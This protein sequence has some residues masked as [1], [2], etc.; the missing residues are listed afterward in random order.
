MQF[1]G[2]LLEESVADRSVLDLLTITKTETWNVANATANQPRVWHAVYYEGDINN[3]DIIAK[4]LCQSL[5]AGEWY[6]NFT[7]N[8]QVHVIFPGKVFV[9]L[10]GDKASRGE[11]QAYGRSIHIAE[12]QLDWGE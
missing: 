8:D 4:A 5:K 11:A 12:S 3:A 9:Y 7:A 6:T 1:N 2:L 10:K